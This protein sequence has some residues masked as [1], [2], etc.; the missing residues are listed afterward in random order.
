LVRQLKASE[1]DYKILKLMPSGKITI[2]TI[3][4]QLLS[5]KIGCKLIYV[6]LSLIYGIS[7]LLVQAA[8]S[9]AHF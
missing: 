8:F 7:E 6:L 4:K 2:T 9:T 3:F 1:C 5:F